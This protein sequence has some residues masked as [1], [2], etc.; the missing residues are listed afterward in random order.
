MVEQNDDLGVQQPLPKLTV[1]FEGELDLSRIDELDGALT[2]ASKLSGVELNVDLTA[3]TFMDS[4]V[5]GW[6]NRAQAEVRRCNGRMRV[7]A[8]RDSTLVKLLS[9][10]GLHDEFEVDLLSG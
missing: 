10:T 2:P 1:R 5:I 3:V 8:A 7:V 9:L 4:T 6:L